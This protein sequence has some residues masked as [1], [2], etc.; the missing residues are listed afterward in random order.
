MRCKPGDLAVVIY[1]RRLENIGKI[2]KVVGVGSHELG[3][4][5]WEIF[6]QSGLYVI[7]RVDGS[8]GQVKEGSSPD[9]WLHPI[10]DSDGE[11][12]TL[13]WKEKECV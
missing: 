9:A 7:Y 6:C 12:E 13:A 3:L 8:H 5:A 1:S 11:D 4:P 10:R 2:V